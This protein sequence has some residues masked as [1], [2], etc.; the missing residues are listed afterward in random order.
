MTININASRIKSEATTSFKG[1][2]PKTFTVGQGLQNA[3]ERAGSLSTPANRFFL[4]ATALS[5]QPWIDLNNK[6]VDEKT[7]KV[8][9]ARTIAKIIAGT[10]VGI[11]VRWACIKSINAL[12]HTPEELAKLNKK[13]TEFN[14]ALI[15]TYLTREQFAE[16][17]RLIKKHRSAIGSIVA[18]GVM[19]ITNFALDVPITKFLTN[20]FVDKFDKS[21]HQSSD[22]KGGK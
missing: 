14:G 9:C 20:V 8:S 15:P 5:I 19:L 7:R 22:M 1:G 4:G 2:A 11:A 3:V 17:G 6:D 10:S 16:A 13:P 18:L 12:T 21:E